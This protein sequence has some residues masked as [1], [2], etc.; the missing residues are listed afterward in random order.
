MNGTLNAM[1]ASFYFY[2]LETSGINPR[3]ARIM[4][5]AG[6]R[7]D[8]QLQPIGEPTNLLIKIT[9]DVIP[10][11]DAIFIT[12]ITPQQTLADG[13][14]EVEFLKHFYSE[15]VTPNTVF[16][17]FNNIRFDD[18][19]MRFLNYRNFYDA[20]EWAW[21]NG[22]GRWD[23]LDVIRMARALRPEGISWPFTSDNKPT[24]RLELLTKA[25]K[26][27]HANAHDALNDVMA[28]IG[29]AR[30][31][32]AK[33]PELFKYLYDLRDKKKITSMITSGEPFVYTSGHYSSTY[34]HTSAAV[35]LAQHSQQGAALIYDL[36]FD[37]TP[38]LTMS[39]DELIA[40]WQFSKDPNRIRLPVKTV[41]YNRNPVIAP[42]GVIKSDSTQERIGLTIETLRANLAIL[43][44][45]QTQ[46]AQN[47]LEAVSKMDDNQS[48]EQAIASNTLLQVDAR[49]YEGFVGSRD[50]KAMQAIRSALP[51]SFTALGATFQDERLQ[52][53]LPL[54][55]ARNFPD[56]L[57]NSEREE[58]EKF[59]QQK[60]F[61]GKQGSLL[62][63]YFARL[64]ELSVEKLTPEKEYLLEEMQL[65]G[66][67]I[68][69]VELS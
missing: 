12:G 42:L 61:E 22:C 31:L 20:Y 66:Q 27:D 41:K 65:Y 43:Q 56:T 47:V 49:L 40:A 39:S 14:T 1:S 9:P 26:L 33:Q 25:N 15:I 17:G 58:W 7:T 46:F 59:C 45:N 57:T 62:A 30:L 63:H 28:T 55:K 19:F 54:Y 44:R 36:R 64:Q 29:V 10:E 69:P 2:D 52:L 60:V 16:V 53:L 51:K 50:K 21:A 18:E 32:Q 3:S 23:M 35:L 5:F 37:P 24:N 8:M 48:R 68:M 11:P 6:Q 67:S 38:F 4:Q 34:L 13:I